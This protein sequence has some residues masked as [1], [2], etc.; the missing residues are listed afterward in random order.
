V[1]NRIATKDCL[2]ARGII[3]SFNSSCVFC[4]ADTESCNHV[5]FSC[6]FAHGV[7]MSIYCWLGFECAYAGAIQDH[8]VQHA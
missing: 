2:I 5:L 3:Q 8:F 4:N 7:W 6:H 1:L